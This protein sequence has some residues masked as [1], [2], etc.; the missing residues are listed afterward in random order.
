L[1][2]GYR[3]ATIRLLRVLK[4]KPQQA[5]AKIVVAPEIHPGKATS[6][7]VRLVGVEIF[8]D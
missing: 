4:G 8:K 6:A 7:D 2:L 5:P 3:K 1:S